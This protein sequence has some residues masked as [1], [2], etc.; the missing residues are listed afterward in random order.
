MRTL[1]SYM[2][3]SESE[4][5]LL[6][7]SS[8]LKFRLY[9]LA[10]LDPYQARVGDA[11]IIIAAAV[12]IASSI[13]ISVLTPKPKPDNSRIQNKD[14]PAASYGVSIPVI[15][16]QLAVQG[17]MIWA[18]PMT[19]KKKKQKS[20]KGGGG[21]KATT[22]V[23]FGTW[24][25]LLAYVG[26][27]N[28]NVPSPQ[29]V[30]NLYYELV[31]IKLN[32]T[33]F[34][35]E[36]DPQ[37]NENAAFFSFYPGTYTQL[38]DSEITALHPT[39]SAYRGHCYIV[40]KLIPLEKYGNTFPTVNA[41]IRRG[42]QTSFQM[43]QLIDFTLQQAEAVAKTTGTVYNHTAINSFT[44]SLDQNKTFNG[45][46][47]SG[48]G[49][50]YKS[51]LEQFAQTELIGKYF[52]PTQNMSNPLTATSSTNIVGL[53][54]LG[55]QTSES[56]T[57]NDS[58]VIPYTFMGTR[59]AGDEPRD[60]SQGEVKD[61]SELPNS[62]AVEYYDINKD[63][64]RNSA[65]IPNPYLVEFAR[66]TA[67]QTINLDF[68]MG[69]SVAA[70]LANTLVGQ[71]H[72]RNR[73]VIFTLSPRYYGQ[74]RTLQVLRIPLD[75]NA[76]N[77]INVQITRLRYGNDLSTE[78][79]AAYYFSS[80]VFDNDLGYAPIPINPPTGFVLG[81]PTT[82]AFEATRS[83]E[84]PVV[85]NNLGVWVGATDLSE[86]C[87]VF[88]RVGSGSWVEVDDVVVDDPGAKGQ[89]IT[90]NLIPAAGSTIDTESVL[91]INMF[92]NIPLTS[93]SQSSFEG[94]QDNSFVHRNELMIFRDAQLIAANQYELSTLW[95]GLRNTET[96]IDDPSNAGQPVYILSEGGWTFV[97]LPESLI[98]NNVEI[99][100]VPNG[101][102]PDDG[103]STFI[104][105][106]GLSYKPA[107]PQ[108]PR[109][110]Q[111][112]NGDILF[113]WNAQ[114]IFPTAWGNG[115]SE[116]PIAE[117]NFYIDLYTPTNVFVIRL[118]LTNGYGSNQFLYPVANQ[119][120]DGI[121]INTYT[122]EMCQVGV[123]GIS[124]F[125]P[126]LVIA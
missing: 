23:A 33:L 106:T 71:L 51:Y 85:A 48:N 42:N 91:S 79:T 39:A 64:N 36:G 124:D 15:Y 43:D 61:M 26:K 96:F 58:I 45:Y 56:V 17:N 31:S 37:F 44:S 30:D 108:N 29:P 10:N 65:S 113:E 93:Q 99:V 118:V 49:E 60:V 109:T 120:A 101:G 80:A 121:D 102:D 19:I 73:Q 62:I 9:L 68:A 67:E 81:Y 92:N 7:G 54:N 115:I 125:T 126:R 114:D 41:V 12:A 77:F 22:E 47:L 2:N 38:P 55:Y 35:K 87:V 5:C 94:Q 103:T 66:S 111:R 82:E 75:Q 16:G 32:D 84:D 34:W 59:P 112:P 27:S 100:L 14:A 97:P 86:S 24:A 89:I 13:L 72:A 117:A 70:A 4:Y 6:M 53:N 3:P 110:V 11:P 119:I 76:T 18:K 123:Y 69:Q 88:Y 28:P 104:Q 46:N 25:T 107:R 90:S 8:A 83:T 74:L 63:Y 116:Q 50:N 1:K 95:R 21:K 78:V 40:F 20:G 52:K 98:G 105:F 122:W 57:D